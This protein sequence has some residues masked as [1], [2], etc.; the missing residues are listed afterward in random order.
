MCPLSVAQQHMITQMVKHTFFFHESLY[1]GAQP[2]HILINPNQIRSN[3]L[4]FLE[5]PMHNHEVYVEIYE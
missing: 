5:N 3:S 4:D 2:K 1:Y